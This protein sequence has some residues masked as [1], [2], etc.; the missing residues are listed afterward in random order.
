MVHSANKTV[1]AAHRPQISHKTKHIAVGYGQQFGISNR[2][3]KPRAL[4][5]AADGVRCSIRGSWG[6]TAWAACRFVLIVDQGR[7][8]AHDVLPVRCPAGSIG[9]F[10]YGP[11][12][13][14]NPVGNGFLCIG[15]PIRLGV[16][17]LDF[18]G[19]A[20]LP[21]DNTSPPNA[22]GQVNVGEQW[23][24]QFLYRDLAGGGAFFNLTDGLSVTFC[25]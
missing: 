16:A 13:A 8:D 22:S 17:S 24:F 5:Q 23:N 19:T 20:I 10:I 25:P 9:I 3:S 12:R 4:K 21:F 1:L 7:D 11:D 15:S 6:R 18:F 2:K 14:L